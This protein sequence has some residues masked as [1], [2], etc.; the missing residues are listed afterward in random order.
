MLRQYSKF[1]VLMLLMSAYF[2]GT[3]A[4][5]QQDVGGVESSNDALPFT[6]SF[7]TIA[8]RITS[9]NAKYPQEK[10][11]L[12][13]DNSHYHKGEDIR[14][15]A[16]VIRDDNL[17]MS[18]ISN[19]LYVELTN[20]YGDVVSKSKQHI[21]EGHAYGTLSL[22][23]ILSNGIYKLRAYTLYM[24][25][26]K[27]NNCFSC[28]LPVFKDTLSCKDYLGDVLQKRQNKVNLN[29][30]PEGGHLLY[31]QNNKV[32]FEIE[33]DEL[34]QDS[35]CEIYLKL[36]NGEKRELSIIHDGMGYFY[37]TPTD[38][39]A[40]ISLNDNSGKEWLF[41]MPEGEKAGYSI[42]V[43]IND[44]RYTTVNI[45]RNVVYRDTLALFMISGGNIDLMQLIPPDLS[46][47]RILNN[48][49][50]EG[51]SKFFLVDRNG[52]VLSER[53]VFNCPENPDS[54]VAK[55]KIATQ[56]RSRALLAIHG[57]PKKN[58]SVSIS[59]A[60]H[61]IHN[62]IG[63]ARSWF[64]LSSDISE[65]VHDPCYYFSR[66]DRH[67]IAADV[68]MLNRQTC[69]YNI[70]QMNLKS[71]ADTIRLPEKNLQIGGRVILDDRLSD[72]AALSV[73]LYNKK[74]NYLIGTTDIDS[75][76]IFLF[77]VPDCHGEWTMIL[78]IL[79]N[80]KRTKGKILL[81]RNVH[82]HNNLTEYSEFVY[83]SGEEYGN[84]HLLSLD[85]ADTLLYLGNHIA[86]NHLL[87]DVK[88][89]GKHRPKNAREAWE[90]ESNGAYK[91]FLYYDC[92]SETEMILDR[93]GDIPS[94]LE[95]LVMKNSSF[96]GNAADINSL[97]GY[98]L[99]RNEAPI[100]KSMI[101]KMNVSMIPDFDTEAGTGQSTKIL[102]V[103]NIQSSQSEDDN[104]F[105]QIWS[106]DYDQKCLITG[107]GLNYNNRPV[108]WILDN[109]FY[110]ITQCPRSIGLK[111]VVSIQPTEAIMPSMLNEYKSIYI[112]EDNSIWRHYIDIPKLSHFRPVTVF[113]YSHHMIN[114]NIKGMRRTY[115]EGFDSP[116]PFDADNKGQLYWN[117]NIELGND[118]VFTD[119]FEI[120]P[121]C[122]KIIITTNS[123]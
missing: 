61:Y 99:I 15:H 3:L 102:D 121:S 12:H 28:W 98:I 58:V 30:H 21:K 44:K 75:T 27:T 10:V 92:D 1:A 70:E 112:S 82:P 52:S 65:T 97:G 101:D 51:I 109:M 91:A 79:Q 37:Y 6:D 29:V 45:K 107:N 32:A 11:Y 74:G 106:E 14:Y 50:P 103:T 108:V 33:T 40:F 119:T 49:M 111:D 4:R 110:S 95:W 17:G 80:G 96:D 86:D 35:T 83:A 122:K 105:K 68:L 24:T 89:Y 19:V 60:Q 9:F 42:A 94:M 117:P 18:N 41:R 76:G 23:N 39:P 71:F 73:A 63:D 8:N 90:S 116:N 77:G 78:N 31:G 55:V 2:S 56:S 104:L 69:R 46:T 100:H 13:I 87:P 118:G 5:C 48:D 93:G 66:D 26:W 54:T 115:F 38:A 114:N 43:G 84:H 85:N 113:L 123:W 120:K 59:D 25:N 88:V 7:N 72:N 47:I 20:R 34:K 67:R 64:L 36:P 81:D 62:D 22:N 57:H 53:A 16:Y